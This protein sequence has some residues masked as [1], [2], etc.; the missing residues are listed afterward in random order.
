MLPDMRSVA[1]H[2]KYFPCKLRPA[3]ICSR[4]YQCDQQEKIEGRIDLQATANEE[5]AKRDGS[6]GLKLG[7]QQSGDQKPRQDKEEVNSEAAG[8]EEPQVFVSIVV[9]D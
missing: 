6:A 9:S 2:E 1:L 4:D 3:V 7:K 8:V 5:A